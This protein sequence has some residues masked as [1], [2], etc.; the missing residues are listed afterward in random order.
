MGMSIAAPGPSPVSTGPTAPEQDRTA[1]NITTQTRPPRLVALDAWRGLTVLMMLLV[2]NVALGNLTPRQLQH[3]PWGGGL[4]FT[5]LVFPWFLYC[6]GAALPFSLAAARRSGLAGWGLV[7]KL[8]ERA[9][10]LYLVGCFVTSAVEGQFTLGLGV[11]QLIALASLAAGV[12]SL[13]GGDLKARW[14]LVIAGALLLG[15]DLFLNLYP[16]P[17]GQVGAFSESLNPVKY[18]NDVLLQ[19]Y[20]LRGLVS[21]VP[22]TALVLLGSVAAQPLK[23]RHPRATWLLLGLGAGLAALGWLSAGHIEFNKAVWTPSYVLYTAGLATLGLLGAYLLGD[24]AGKARWLAPFTVAGR[25]ALFAYVATILFKTWVL[26]AWNVGWTGKSLSIQDSLLALARG[27]L[28]QWWGGWAYTL[29]LIAL[30]WAVLA[31]MARRNIIWK[32]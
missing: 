26:G 8:V 3:A 1:Q 24:A 32:L 9:A 10:L 7:R 27:H 6:A 20:G 12:I 25:N 13:I 5:D 11:L 18:L 31:Y 17:G 30:V 29:G 2:N 22:T 4:T 28:G 16:L 14:R 21:V 19:P 23:N 15:Y